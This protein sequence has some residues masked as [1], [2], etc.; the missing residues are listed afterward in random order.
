MR[1]V[2]SPADHQSVGQQRRQPG[3]GGEVARLGVG[4]RVE[5]AQDR[6]RRRVRAEVARGGGPETVAGLSNY[7]HVQVGVRVR[8]VAEPSSATTIS[9]SSRG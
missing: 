5:E 1:R 6:C 4:V 9:I 8:C 2:A 7:G 3:D